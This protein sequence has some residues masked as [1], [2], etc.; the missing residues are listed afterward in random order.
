MFIFCL[1][2]KLNIVPITCDV[3][4]T[5]EYITSL[6]YKEKVPGDFIFANN[7]VL[8]ILD[9]YIEVPP[10]TALYNSINF[11]IY[12]FEVIENQQNDEKFDE[13][14]SRIL[15]LGKSHK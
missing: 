13:K 5:N 7:K 3:V 15:N 6:D 8:G 4:I 14:V 2:N 12:R 10:K 9:K 1:Q 11:M